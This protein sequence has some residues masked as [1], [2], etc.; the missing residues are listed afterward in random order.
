MLYITQAWIAFTYKLVFINLHKVVLRY[1][2][3]ESETS[4]ILKL[5][6][7]SS[8]IQRVFFYVA[9]YCHE[10]ISCCPGPHNHMLSLLLN[11]TK[12]YLSSVI[13]SYGKPTHFHLPRSGQIQRAIKSTF[14]AYHILLL[15]WIVKM[16]TAHLLFILTLCLEHEYLIPLHVSSRIYT[17]I[18]PT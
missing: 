8:H 12:L 9:Y 17:Y 11:L 14:E 13:I 2:M 6:I 15:C 18:I 16:L 10:Y 7:S 3:R 1:M 5:V 4:G